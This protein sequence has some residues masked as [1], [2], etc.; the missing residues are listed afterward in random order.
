MGISYNQDD[1]PLMCFN[2]PKLFQLNWFPSYYTTLT[3]PDYNWSGNLYHS[4][5]I[6]SIP[7]GGMMLIKCNGFN[8]RSSDY[9]DYFISFNSATGANS[10]TNEARNQV[11]VHSSQTRTYLNAP[12]SLLV[13]KLN[14]GD[15]YEFRAL[16]IDVVV[17]VTAIDTSAS[18]PF[19]TVTI[20]SGT[21]A[22]STSQSPSVSVVP[23]LNPSIAPSSMPS[24]VNGVSLAPTLVY[25][26][27]MT[28]FLSGNF[29]AASKSG[30]MFDVTATEDLMITRLDIKLFYVKF[31]GNNFETDIEIYTK[32]G[33]FRG[34]ETNRGSVWT[35][36]MDRTTV[37]PPDQN[38]ASTLGLTPITEDMM[39]PI[40]V[41]AG[42][43]VAIYITNRDA[44]NYI[45]SGYLENA[46]NDY[47]STDGALTLKRGLF[48]KYA[49]FTD[50]ENDFFW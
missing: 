37:S 29:Y 5:S 32:P 22:P 41:G 45:E 23:S 3:S 19:A 10:G 46:Q 39:S 30:I 24:P 13:A 2:A 31:G 17:T 4:T 42:G 11:V 35:K 40:L 9:L 28:W 6:G 14:A 20:A 12:K 8:A 16:G 36:H 25:D 47:T 34:H 44:N 50:S 26:S 1:G 38:D 33:G 15:T 18:P 49:D 27:I 43:T 48:R 7:S 21:E